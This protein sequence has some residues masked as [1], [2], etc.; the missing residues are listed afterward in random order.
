MTLIVQA[1]LPRLATKIAD[2]A[3]DHWLFVTIRYADFDK[4]LR[5]RHLH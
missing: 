3:L 1:F 2:F 5:E 4:A